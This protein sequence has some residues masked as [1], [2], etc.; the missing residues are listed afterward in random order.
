M[1]MRCSCGTWVLGP[2]LLSGRLTIAFS[3]SSKGSDALPV[4]SRHL[5]SAAHIHP[6]SHTTQNTNRQTERQTDN[7]RNYSVLP[8]ILHAG[9]HFWVLKR[10][11]PVPRSV[12]RQDKA[13]ARTQLEGTSSLWP[14]HR[15]TWPIKDRGAADWSQLS[16]SQRLCQTTTYVSRE[17]ANGHKFSVLKSVSSYI[18]VRGNFPHPEYPFKSVFLSDSQHSCLEVCVCSL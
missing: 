4:L 12:T 14:T 1:G 6:E 9:T 11:F 16:C 15:Q 10:S 8:A 2:A 18:H 5:P 7:K 13:R 3:S 17:V